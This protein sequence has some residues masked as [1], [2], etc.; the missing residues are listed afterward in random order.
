V[1]VLLKRDIRQ[2][3][4]MDMYPLPGLLLNI[5][6]GM[7]PKLTAKHWRSPVE[8]VEIFKR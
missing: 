2:N 8:A 3:E 4:K 7:K 5:E 6:I 1:K